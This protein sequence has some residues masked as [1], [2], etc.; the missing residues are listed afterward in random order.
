MYELRS[1][2][3]IFLKEEKHSLIITFEDEVFQSKLAYLCDIFEKLNQLNISLQRRDTQILQLYDK[4]T[5]FKRKLRLWKT[6]LWE[7]EKEK[8]EKE[9]SVMVFHFKV[10]YKLII[11]ES[12]LALWCKEY[13]LFAF[14]FSNLTF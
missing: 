5:A 3:I 8:K 7:N 13:D 9:N 14:G 2:I 1:E 6:G 4:I 11:W 10:T 12:L